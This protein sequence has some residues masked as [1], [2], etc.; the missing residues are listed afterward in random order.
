MKIT[1]PE[2]TFTYAPGE[3]KPTIRIGNAKDEALANLETAL[4]CLIAAKGAGFS[5][6]LELMLGSA[7]YQLDKLV[8]GA[9]IECKD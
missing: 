4:A 2:M 3:S 1:L 5:E 8:V 9:R 7:V 6:A